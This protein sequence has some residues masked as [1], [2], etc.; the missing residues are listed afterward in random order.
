[1]LRRRILNSLDLTQ[2]KYAF[3]VK[4]LRTGET[5]A[6]NEAV[7]VPSAS[8]I[9]IFVMAEIM[10]QVRRGTLS[11]KHRLAVTES[12]KVPFSILTLLET[13][14]TYTLRD[15]ITLMIVQSDNT[16]TNMLIDI[17][18]AD[19]INRLT[20]GLD[21]QGTALQRKMMDAAARQ[22]GRENLTTAADMARTMELLFTGKVIDREASDYMLCILKKQLDTSMM[23]L[24]IP[25]DTV[26]AHKTGELERLDHET[27]IVY[28]RN[29]EYIF[30]VL[31][32][33]A[34]TNNYARQVLGKVSR[35][36]YDYFGKQ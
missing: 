20:A 22:E 7:Q 3:V 18:G 24:D 30:T 36:V 27:A 14:N 25:D 4:N 2:A 5:A 33:E 15:L 1:M 23:M 35:L 8:L 11:L 12:D 16:A 32:W 28:L 31:V 13:G 19:N 21:L 10:R 34:A 9:K 6:Y 17:A 26:V 29:C